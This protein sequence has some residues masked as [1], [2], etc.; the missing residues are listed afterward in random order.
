[1]PWKRL[2]LPRPTRGRSR[3][4]LDE[5]VPA[6]VELQ[7]TQHG[8]H[9]T[10]AKRL[11]LLGHS[12]EDQAALCWREQR[13]LITFDWDFFEPKNIPRH[14]A[15]GIV[16]IDC[17]PRKAGLVSQLIA[18]FADLE[19]VTGAV[20]RKRR[21][22]IGANGLVSIW[23]TAGPTQAPDFKYRFQANR[24]PFVWT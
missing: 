24:P 4:H 20:S 17:D 6:I 14:R 9:L 7:L 12:D 23:A 8:Y 13:T 19:R 21:V 1:M 15:P 22:V 18:T 16:I 10:T 2:T 3:L 11:H 5:S